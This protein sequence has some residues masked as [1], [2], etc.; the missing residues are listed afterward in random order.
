MSEDVPEEG[1]S[2]QEQQPTREQITIS[3]PEAMIEA[4]IA[5]IITDKLPDIIDTTEMRRVQTGL[6]V[7]IKLEEGR[8][9]GYSTR[10][11]ER[12]TLAPRSLFIV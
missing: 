2:T 12:E 9:S 10:V 1:G 3:V 6:V 8:A 4:I 5:E 7:A 11:L